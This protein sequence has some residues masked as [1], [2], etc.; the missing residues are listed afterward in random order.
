MM[1]PAMFSAKFEGWTHL[2]KVSHL[3]RQ[4]YPFSMKA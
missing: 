3:P 2:T 4:C 1:S